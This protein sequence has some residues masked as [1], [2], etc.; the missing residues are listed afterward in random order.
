MKKINLRDG[1]E[2]DSTF[3]CLIKLTL[4][5]SQHSFT[6]TT[7][8]IKVFCKH[9]SIRKLFVSICESST[10]KLFFFRLLIILFL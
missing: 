8:I 2:K 9:F 4:M 1:N 6:L 5:L 7:L 3:F 10:V